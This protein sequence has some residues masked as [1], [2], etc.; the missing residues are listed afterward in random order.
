MHG[1]HSELLVT[2]LAEPLKWLS[3]ARYEKVV[4]FRLSVVSEKKQIK[5]GVSLVPR[6][7]VPCAS[8]RGFVD[9]DIERPQPVAQTFKS[10]L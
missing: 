7:V 4:G 5:T 6:I 1:A 8:K 2:Y 10:R 3:P 9:G